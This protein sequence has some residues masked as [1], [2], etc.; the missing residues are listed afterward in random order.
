[1]MWIISSWSASRELCLPV[2]RSCC[3]LQP[4]Q[5]RFS[6]PEDMGRKSRT[7]T[8]H[9]GRENRWEGLSEKAP[10]RSAIGTDRMHCVV[11]IGRKSLF[12]TTAIESVAKLDKP[13][14]L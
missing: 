4:R 11:H 13:D 10:C 6:A 14:A 8:W 1:M 12:P 5:Y 9:T 2:R 3:P 7:G